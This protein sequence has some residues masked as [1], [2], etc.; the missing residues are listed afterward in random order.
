MAKRN[1][2]GVPIPGVSAGSR[3][4]GAMEASNAMVSWPSG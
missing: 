4:V 3:K 1:T 2:N